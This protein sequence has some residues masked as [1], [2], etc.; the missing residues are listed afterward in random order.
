LLD[1]SRGSWGEPADDVTCL[2]INYLHYALKDCGKFD[3]PFA[4]L[5]RLFWEYYMKKTRDSEMFDLVQPFFA[6]RVLVIT[7]PK[8]YPDDPPAMRRKLLNFGHSVLGEQR[9]HIDRIPDYL[10]GS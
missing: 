6:F 9:F 1:R 5:F 8:F 3:G 10:E 2:S 4:E 7:N